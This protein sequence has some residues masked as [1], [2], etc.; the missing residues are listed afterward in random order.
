M[1]PPE[2]RG[3]VLIDPPFEQPGEFDA[4]L[5]ALL[6]AYRKWPTGSYMLWYPLKDRSA[7]GR[8]VGG[9]ATSGMRRVLQLHL[10]VGDPDAGPLGGSGLVLVNPPY[11]LK[12]DAE[13]LLPWL[14]ETLARPGQAADWTARWLVGE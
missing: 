3:L 5:S 2:R 8:F 10:L 13:T 11:T 6:R 7:V 12:D 9:L 14:A 1:P 4:L